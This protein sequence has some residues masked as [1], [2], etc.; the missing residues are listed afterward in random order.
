[1]PKRHPTTR[2]V[3]QAER[4]ANTVE[5]VF[6]WIDPIRIDVQ[7]AEA[8]A[9]AIQSLIGVWLRRERPVRVEVRLRDEG[10]RPAPPGRVPPCRR[11][12][13]G[14]GGRR[15]TAFRPPHRFF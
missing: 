7:E 5:T 8:L 2:P 1:M 13:A 10:E 9:V 12:R 6:F 11:P 3:T 4:D 15:E 14:E